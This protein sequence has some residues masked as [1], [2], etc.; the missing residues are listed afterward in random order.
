MPQPKGVAGLAAE[1]GRAARLAAT[2]E[3]WLDAE[4]DQLILWAPVM[5]GLGIALWFLLPAPG[6]WVA[7]A[8]L[9][10]AIAAA[11]LA[12]PPGRLG[13][14]A[15]T[16]GPLVRLGVGEARERA[17]LAAAPRL[18]AEQRAI[19]LTA[20]VERVED[21]SGR[22]QWRL[23]L[24]PHDPGLPPRVRIALRAPPEA[25]IRPGEQVRLGATLSPPPGPLVPGGSES[26]GPALF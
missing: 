17:K 22:E 15:G 19:W 16:G 12:L 24:A 21:R 6:Q 14:V 20:T 8:A 2:I 11:G 3:A 18:E 25:A 9:A 10:L 4:R 7:A 26:G 23:F 5:L 13:R 1:P